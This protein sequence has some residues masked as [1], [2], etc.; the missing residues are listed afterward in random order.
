M[1]NQKIC[2]ISFD[3]WNY[4][5]HIVEALQKKHIDAFHIKIG[6]YKH[7]SLYARVTNTFSKIFL[8]KNPKV[9]KRQENIIEELDKRG[10]QD[11]ILVINPEI[12]EK[13]FHQKIKSYTKKYIAYLYD[14]VDRY[15]VEHLLDGVFDEIFS[16]DKN[17][18]K[19]YSFSEANNYNYINELTKEKSETETVDVIYI[20]SFDSRMDMIEKIGE[21][22][23]SKDIKFNF[24]IV[25]KK[26]TLYTFKN[27]FSRKYRHL[28]FKRKR[29][30]QEK[31]LELY[32]NS[33]VILDIVRENQ[34]GLSFRIFEA[35]GLQKKIIT[36]NATITD[37]DFYNPKN[38]LV[39]DSDASS[40]DKKFIESPY[41]ILTSA[42][43]AKYT[44]E[45]WVGTIF[46]L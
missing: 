32:Q 5:Y 3:H 15:P 30:E 18:I 34:S 29:I 11:Q 22:L 23:Q 12:I 38:I 36:N 41:Q 45:N 4:D 28:I 31:T 13:E 6:A 33:K 17:D 27:F 35:L 44:I 26:A 20:G 16:F 7:K 21:K 1:A 9:T 25:G 46:K 37:F 8:G 43:Y 10:I 19:K 42:I 24:F 40:I 14:S 39:I 2:V